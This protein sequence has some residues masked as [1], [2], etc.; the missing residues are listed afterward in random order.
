MPRFRRTIAIDD[1]VLD[2]LLRD[3]VGHDKHPAAFL[4]YL[5]LYGHAARQRWQPVA[6]SLTDLAED[7]GLSRSAVQTALERLRGRELI[8][9]ERVHA[10]AKPTHRVLRHWRK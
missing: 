1:Y 4:V 8:D 2:I 5:T 10:T 6:A 9:S 3:L 7:T